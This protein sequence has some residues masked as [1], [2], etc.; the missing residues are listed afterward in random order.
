M[1]WK[2]AFYALGAASAAGAIAMAQAGPTGS[3]G[4][5]PCPVVESRDWSA[6]IDAEPGPGAEPRLIVTGEIDL[7][8]PGYRSQWSIGIADRRLPPAQHLNLAL[9][10][11]QGIVAQVITTEKLRFEA[12]AAYPEY[13]AIIVRCGDTA[14]ATISPVPI[15]R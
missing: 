5:A 14:L 11:P 15:A 9:T 2:T 10:P 6:W 3:G 1:M 13:R 12:K 7:P 8:S 4:G